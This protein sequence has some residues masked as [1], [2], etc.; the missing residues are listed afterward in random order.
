MGCLEGYTPC[1]ITAGKRQLR[2]SGDGWDC[3]LYTSG[4]RLTE[5]AQGDV[6]RGPRADAGQ[7]TQSLD[8][9]CTAFLQVELEAAIGNPRREKLQALHALA[10]HADAGQIGLGKRCLLYTSLAACSLPLIAAAA[11]AW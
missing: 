7:G 4:I 6:L 3:L 2:E 11:P 5:G 10:G 1:R 8:Q 9:R